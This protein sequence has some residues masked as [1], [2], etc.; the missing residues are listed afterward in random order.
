MLVNLIDAHGSDALLRLRISNGCV[1]SWL[2]KLKQL[3]VL[4]RRPERHMT[5]IMKAE[6]ILAL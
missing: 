5:D 2:S 1:I 4:P 6:E 3:T